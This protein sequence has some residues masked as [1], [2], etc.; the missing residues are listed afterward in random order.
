M[1][2]FDINKINEPMEC[3]NKDDLIE[4]LEKNVKSSCRY[5]DFDIELSNGD[6]ICSLF[7]KERMTF[8][9]DFRLKI[10]K[11]YFEVKK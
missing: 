2:S 10:C 9:K 5:C 3:I 7:K 11:K 8:S 6:I 4:F 1:I